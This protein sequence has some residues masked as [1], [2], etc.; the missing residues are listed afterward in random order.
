MGRRAAPSYRLFFALK[1][2]AV[3]ARRIDHYAAILAGGDPRILPAHQHVTLGITGDAPDYPRAQIDALHR[4]ATRIMADPFDLLLDR[5]C[6]GGR[7][8]ALRPSR[9]NAALVRLQR[10]VANAMQ[11][12]G[13]TPRE[14]WH[15]S[16]HQTLFYRDGPPA[17]RRIDG[18]GWR[19]EQLVLICSH[20]GRTR[21]DVVGTWAL[22]GDAQYRLF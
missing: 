3:V 18:F 21:H 19:V 17:Q 5:L 1:P 6:Y 7:S 9:S 4:A 8:A 22:Q 16:P 10:Q 13:A 20:V 14:D 11:R 15:F 2:P 12:A